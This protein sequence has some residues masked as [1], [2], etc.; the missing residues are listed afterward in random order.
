VKTVTCSVCTRTDDNPKV[1]GMQPDMPR[2]WSV[3]SIAEAGWQVQNFRLCPDCTQAV[4]GT[5]GSRVKLAA[6][7]R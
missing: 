7:T 4:R 2:R 1:D 5:I 6:V 3:L